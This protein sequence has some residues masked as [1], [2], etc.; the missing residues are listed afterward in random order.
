MTVR[1][2]NDIILSRCGYI[3]HFHLD[4]TM[5][6]CH[7]SM[8]L[9]LCIMVESSQQSWPCGLES[10][11]LAIFSKTK[12]SSKQICTSTTVSWIY[13]STLKAVCHIPVDNNYNISLLS[14][15]LIW[16]RNCDICITKYISKPFWLNDSFT[17]V[18]VSAMYLKN[19]GG[20][21]TSY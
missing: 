4:E 10:R 21:L 6:S 15:A 13:M 20:N 12:F 11:A 18:F 5:L 19:M 9:K 16:I 1:C 7:S 8:W 17:P 14:H 3:P 2:A